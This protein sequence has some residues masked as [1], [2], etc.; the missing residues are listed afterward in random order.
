M[1]LDWILFFLLLAMVPLLSWIGWKLGE[2][3]AEE[4]R[5]KRP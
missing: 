3:D 5:R 4:M 2:I 1:M